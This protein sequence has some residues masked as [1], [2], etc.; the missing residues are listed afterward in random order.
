M[1]SGDFGSL[2]L[3][4]DSIYGLRRRLPFDYRC[5]DCGHPTKI[6]SKRDFNFTC[7]CG[8]A[9]CLRDSQFD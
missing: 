1:D 7:L 5:D 8:V 4:T 6:A 3:V 9:H 2:K